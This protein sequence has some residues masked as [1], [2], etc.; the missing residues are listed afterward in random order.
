MRIAA[1]PEPAHPAT[2]LQLPGSKRAMNRGG[3]VPRKPKNGKMPTLRQVAEAAN[4]SPSTVS[5]ALNDNGDVS[6]RTK[7]EVR[8]VARELGYEPKRAKK[9]DKTW[10][11]GLIGL[12]T[13][14]IVGKPSMPLLA[15][16]EQVLGLV[17]HAALLTN[18]RGEAR[19]ERS[20]IEQLLSRGVDG[21]IVAGPSADPREPVDPS[22]L[23]ETPIVYAVSPSTNPRDCSVVTNFEQGARLALSHL[24]DIGRTH[25]A[26]IGGKEEA[27]ANR[28]RQR[29]VERSLEE[30]GLSL[31]SP[32]RYRDWSSSWGRTETNRLLDEGVSFDALFCFNDRIARGA[33]EVLLR[34]GIRVP[35]DVAIVGF[36][37]WDEFLLD[38]EVPLTTIDNHAEQI[39]SVAAGYLL[40]AIKGRPHSGLT[41]VP[42]ELVRRASTGL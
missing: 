5:K 2:A 39:G 24:A 25:I 19:L 40:D 14:D 35:E 17:R 31:V 37:N 4:V 21:L 29:G 23:E 30:H 15:G 12:V 34:R 13:C 32:A 27:F 26:V 10:H 36:D 38:T 11:S 8:R 33:E 22:L 9:V 6:A 41:R 16:C 42:C 7:I 28:E 3:S 20:R 18:S 1:V